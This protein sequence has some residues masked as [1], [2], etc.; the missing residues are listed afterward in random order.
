MHKMDTYIKPITSK[1]MMTPIMYFIKYYFH[2]SM[3]PNPMYINYILIDQFI[4]NIIIL[5]NLILI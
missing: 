3:H 5:F 2:K 1:Q 4:Y